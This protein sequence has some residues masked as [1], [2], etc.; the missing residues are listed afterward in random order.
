MRRFRALLVGAIIAIVAVM[1]A[2]TT[3]FA[4][5]D[6]DVLHSAELQRPIDSD[7][8]TADSATA[9]TQDSDFIAINRWKSAA[10]GFSTNIGM[11]ESNAMMNAANRAGIQSMFM[12]TGNMWWDA[13]ITTTTLANGVDAF[14][15]MAYT[16]DSVAESLA[17]AFIGD[18]G[19]SPLSIL[20][21][22][23]VIMAFFQV[24]RVNRGAGLF[25]RLL[26][27][28][29]I[30]G[31]IM[32]A[33]TALTSGANA[34]SNQT[35]ESYTPPIATPSWLVSV[36]NSGVDKLG[37]LTAA[38]T[39]DATKNPMSLAAAP[40]NKPMSCVNTLEAFEEVVGASDS[41]E[42]QTRA[43]VDRLW[44]MTGLRAWI[45]TQFGS[46]NNIG[47][48][49]F[50]YLL[51]LKSS[52]LTAADTLQMY[53][54]TAEHKGL[55]SSFPG[56]EWVAGGEANRSVPKLSML[57]PAS[58]RAMYGAVTA[59]AACSW[60]GTKFSGRGGFYAQGTA[61]ESN[62]G[63]NP[64]EGQASN[65]GTDA[66]EAT[67]AGVGWGLDSTNIEAACQAA[68]AAPITSDW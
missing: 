4:T 32:F 57:E 65:A 51:D 40:E 45:S 12:A 27:L 55:A 16:V 53:Q 68:F 58:D 10:S 41:R 25:K 64:K 54:V 50:C 48:D 20:L 44:Q 8:D 67:G 1:S 5:P 35:P 59:M 22:L 33:A 42:V 19:F 47:N 6:T 56:W 24:V 52:E 11:S 28:S 31:Y 2:P 36:A 43:M 66:A 37:N 63:F 9:D 18:G 61:S 14:T 29:V 46:K 34:P 26:A 15:S 23:A 49:V 13:A 17:K 7:L 3:A 30:I 39:L 21:I 38:V 60:D 62:P